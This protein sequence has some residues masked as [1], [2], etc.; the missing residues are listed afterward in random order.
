[1]KP[2]ELL[3]SLLLKI[4]LARIAALNSIL[5]NDLKPKRGIVLAVL[6]AVIALGARG[7]KPLFNFMLILRPA[8]KLTDS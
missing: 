7:D 1:M 3:V 6:V 5:L 4:L 8:R 2:L